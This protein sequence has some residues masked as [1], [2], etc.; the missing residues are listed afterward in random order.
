MKFVVAFLVPLLVLSG[1]KYVDLPDLGDLPDLPE[2]PQFSKPKPPPKPPKNGI[3]FISTCDVPEG[4]IKTTGK[5]EKSLYSFVLN[6]K[7]LG[8]CIDDDKTDRN[9]PYWERAELSQ[10]GHIDLKRSQVIRFDARFLHGFSGKHESFFQIHNSG[11]K[12]PAAA[13]LIL[14]WHKG[15]LEM[16]LLQ[17][18]GIY[19]PKRFPDHTVSNF[20][21]WSKWQVRLKRISKSLMAVDVMSEGKRIGRGHQAWFAACAKPYVKFGIYRPGNTWVG[22]ETSVAEFRK[23]SLKPLHPRK[24]KRKLRKPGPPLRSNSTKKTGS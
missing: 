22:N 10:I 7:D 4:S 20:R 12:C 1:C 8:G 18:S 3:A 14:N 5:E 6:D 16:A 9:A 23:F 19:K 2:L 15:Q 24:P 21:S 13:S 11:E 17:E